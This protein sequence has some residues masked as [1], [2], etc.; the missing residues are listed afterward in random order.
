MADKQTSKPDPEAVLTIKVRAKARTIW[1]DKL[2]NE[3]DVFEISEKPG[4]I[5]RYVRQGVIAIEVDESAP[6]DPKRN[7]RE[8][9]DG[10][11]PAGGGEQK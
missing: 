7:Q 8:P 6:V 3:G 5:E 4:V 9:D 1:G 10:P 11:K 2:Q